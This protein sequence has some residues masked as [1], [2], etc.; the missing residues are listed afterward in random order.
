MRTNKL[1][2]LTIYRI[3]FYVW[4]KILDKKCLAWTLFVTLQ[5]VSSDPRNA[6]VT[7]DFIIGRL[8]R[9]DSDIKHCSLNTRIE[10]EVC[11]VMFT[12]HC[13]LSLNSV[14]DFLTRLSLLRSV[15]YR[16]PETLLSKA[17]KC[18]NIYTSAGNR[19]VSR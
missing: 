4:Y 17:I 9:T 19:V 2:Q 12:R 15:V 7:L 13:S 16:K 8:C 11:R 5:W 18:R 1:V 14:G 6:V 10:R 3:R